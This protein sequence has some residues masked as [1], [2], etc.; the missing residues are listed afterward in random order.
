M[1]LEVVPQ[2]KVNRRLFVFFF[3]KRIRMIYRDDKDSGRVNYYHGLVVS[4]R[5]GRVR[6]HGAGVP[7]GGLT[8]GRLRHHMTCVMTG[9]EKVVCRGESSGRTSAFR[10]HFEGREVERAHTFGS[11]ARW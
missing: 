4:Q 10:G 1:A 3:V 2:Q 7:L 11:R 8:N 5:G 6:A 9:V